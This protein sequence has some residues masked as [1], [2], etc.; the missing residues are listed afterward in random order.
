[1]KI[2]F[3]D[4]SR[5]FKILLMSS[6]LPRECGIATYSYDL[7]QGLLQKFGANCQIDCCALEDSTAQFSYPLEVKYRLKVDQPIAYKSLAQELNLK[8]A[9][10]AILIAHEFGLFGGNFGQDLLLFLSENQLPVILNFHTI[11]PNPCPKLY[12]VVNQLISH[13]S[14][15]VCMTNASASLLIEAYVC[16]EEKCQVI[17]HGTAL[18]AQKNTTHLKLKLGL[19]G[20][21]ILTT[22]G[23]L[24]RGKS[25]E[26]ALYA[27]A[28]LKNKFPNCLYVILGKTHPEVAK[29]EGET[30]RLF[31]TELTQR[32]DISANVLFVDA[33][34]DKDLLE[35]Y[36]QA[37]DI[38]LFTSC[39]PNQAVSGTFAYAMACGCPI[40][41]TPIPQAKDALGSAGILVNFNNPEQMAKAIEQ[42]F[43]NEPVHAAMKQAAFQQSK[44][45]AWPNVALQYMRLFEKINLKKKKNQHFE[46]PDYNL[47]HLKK[48]TTSVG[49]LQFCKAEEPMLSSGYTLDDNARALI[50]LVEYYAHKPDYSI[51][52][53]IRIHFEFIERM[54]LESGRFIN[55]LDHNEKSTRQNSLENLDDANGRAIW[56]LGTFASH[57]QMFDPSYYAKIQQMLEKSIGILE[58]IDSPRAIAF[59]IKGLMKYNQKENN[60][61]VIDLI[62]RLADKLEANYH[63]HQQNEHHWFEPSLTYANAV[64]PEALLMASQISSN[65]QQQKIADRCFEYLLD[66]L[67]EEG[68]LRV[69]S[70]QTWFIP[71][72]EKNCTGQQPIEVAYT[73]LALSTFY[74]ITKIKTYLLQMKTA[75][76]WYLGNNSLN[77]IVYNP[78]SGGCL[79]GIEAHEV[80]I[81]QGAESTVTYLMARNRMETYF[82]G[83]TQ[84]LFD[85]QQRNQQPTTYDS[86]RNLQAQKS[87]SA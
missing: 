68:Q 67:F 5:P 57:R 38:Y 29:I 11:L 8:K 27:L 21:P 75:F 59:T 82:K 15:V 6:C 43:A 20:T 87:T 28:L 58:A 7:R 63:A 1:M 62:K 12:A 61:Q 78:V 46:L 54:Q 3:P 39:D 37:T 52:R 51:L 35:D 14:A 83:L 19:N 80:N 34:A 45:S 72:Q 48:C 69:I 79:D 36:L 77:Q 4:S 18:L 50:G 73:I 44:P 56:A 49:L 2:M 22:F 10:D 33:F 81:N 17:A 41:S 23:L 25:I 9:Y 53:N 31:L 65:K 24:S 30:Y 74:E 76:D 64:L 13:A 71:G 86:L 66:I 70:N 60:M 32:L 47:G 85:Q 42:V 16:P 40:V 84:D 26:T 55:Y